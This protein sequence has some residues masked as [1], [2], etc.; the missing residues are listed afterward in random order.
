MEYGLLL[1]PVWIFPDWIAK[2]FP[3]S[4]LPAPPLSKGWGLEAAVQPSVAYKVIVSQNGNYFGLFLTCWQVGA[5]HL[6]YWHM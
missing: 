6:N 3:C 5:V 4:P 1:F 2:K